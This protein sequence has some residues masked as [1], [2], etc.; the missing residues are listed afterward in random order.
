M[1]LGFGAFALNKVTEWEFIT[2]VKKYFCVSLLKNI[3][4]LIFLIFNRY[5]LKLPWRN[6]V[7]SK[8]LRFIE[9]RGQFSWWKWVLMFLNA[10]KCFRQAETPWHKAYKEH[11]PTFTHQ[12]HYVYSINTTTFTHQYH[13]VYLSCYYKII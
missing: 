6:E 5:L 2:A 8:S 12:Y 11:S 1:L 10:F 4:L 13:Y 9:N 3:L 7:K